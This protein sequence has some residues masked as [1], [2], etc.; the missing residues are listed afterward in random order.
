MDG[1][2][3]FQGKDIDSAIRN[4]CAFFNAKRN[5]LDI[6]IVHDAKTGIFGIVGMRDALIRARRSPSGFYEMHEPFCQD[7]SFQ[8]E[9]P[10]K[11]K[12]RIHQAGKRKAPKEP[13]QMLPVEDAVREEQES[14]QSAPVEEVAFQGE[15]LPKPEEKDVL[16]KNMPLDLREEED[17]EDYPPITDEEIR[18]PAFHALVEEVLRALVR[19]IIGEEISLSIDGSNMR[20]HVHIEGPED[21]GLLIGREGQTLLAVQYLCAR[22]LMRRMGRALYIQLD[23]GSYRQRQEDKLHEF[24]LLLAEK[25]RATNRSFSTRPLSSYHRRLVHVFLQNEPDIQI[26]SIGAGAL[27]R[28]VISCRRGEK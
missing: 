2:Y 5:H 26:K 18:D 15:M 6:E 4:A 9:E 13:E 24:V 23:A 14:L 17:G 1:F 21:F 3:E 12:N 7:L 11:G 16:Q 28:V 20:V 27:R 22:I 19:P 25:A 10:K 8:H